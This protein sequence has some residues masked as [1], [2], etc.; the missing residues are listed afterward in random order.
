MRCE[1]EPDIDKDCEQS[2]KRKHTFWED[3]PVGDLLTYLCRPRPWANK[4]VAIAHNAK[5]FDL[6]LILNRAILL[7]WQPEL[8][9]GQKFMCMRLEHLLFLDSVSFL[10]MALRSLP[11]AFG[12]TASKSWYPHYFNTKANMDY[13]GR[14]PDIRYYGADAMK[15]S[16]RTEFLRWYETQR[17]QTFDNRRVLEE[18]CQDD[19]TVLRQACQVLRR[20]FLQIGNVEVFLESVTIASACN[21]VLRRKFLEPDVIGL[22]PAGGYTGNVNYSKKAIMCLIHREQTDGCKI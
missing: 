10:P 16:E 15:D 17:S 11:E 12:L 20:E 19:V 9:N 5:A 3:D 22:I 6:H 21:K 14:I 7:K 13:V 8:M 4:I 2:G 1:I 18:Y